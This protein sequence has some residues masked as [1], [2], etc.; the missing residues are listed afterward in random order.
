LVSDKAKSRK[1]HLHVL[2]TSIPNRE[3]Q[4][5]TIIHMNELLARDLG[6]VLGITQVHVDT[7]LKA[8]TSM[9]QIFGVKRREQIMRDSEHHIDALLKIAKENGVAD[10]VLESAQL[11][12]RTLRMMRDLYVNETWNDATIIGEWSTMFEGLALARWASIRG[13]VET[14]VDQEN[15]VVH[16]DLLTLASD[17]S[18]FHHSILHDALTHFHTVGEMSAQTTSSNEV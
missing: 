1:T 17:A 10:I 16:N 6:H 8:H 11:T 9:E 4:Y 12:E 13:T 5:D 3:L 2:D 18:Q 14:L 7:C 15:S